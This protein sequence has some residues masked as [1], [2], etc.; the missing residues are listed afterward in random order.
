MY[1][2]RFGHGYTLQAKVKSEAGGNEPQTTGVAPPPPT[3]GGLPPPYTAQPEVPLQDMGLVYH[4]KGFIQQSFYGSVLLEEHQV[5]ILYIF[6]L[7]FCMI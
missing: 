3:T 6:S 7:A 5:Y 4:L 1:V 2:Y